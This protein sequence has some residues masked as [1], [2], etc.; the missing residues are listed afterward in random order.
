MIKRFSSLST[1]SSAMQL[2]TIPMPKAFF[3]LGT[4]SML[5][6]FLV[7]ILS[8]LDLGVF[9]Y[10]ISP[11]VA[12]ITLLYQ[13]GVFVLA[14]RKRKK[15][16]PS[17]YSTVVLTAY[18]ISAGWLTAFIATSVMIAKGKPA[19]EAVRSQGLVAT[20]SSQW[21]QWFFALCEFLMVGGMG[22]RG[23]LLAMR[24]GEPESWRRQEV[25]E[26]S[27]EPVLGETEW[28]GSPGFGQAMESQPPLPIDIELSNDSRHTPQY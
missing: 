28:P 7:L 21:A 9:S 3:F 15:Y 5:G 22:V 18:I 26:K 12:I 2:E 8:M 20:V 10:W 24:D 19:V 23:H 6:A 4:A 17:Y 11:P 14:H 27:P 1:T 16:L 13:G 25:E